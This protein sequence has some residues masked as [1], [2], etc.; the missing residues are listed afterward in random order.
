MESNLQSFINNDILSLFLGILNERIA[1]LILA[2]SFTAKIAQETNST[3]Y[4]RRGESVR[5]SLKRYLLL[6]LGEPLHRL[7]RFVGALKTRHDDYQNK[8]NL[9][10]EDSAFGTLNSQ[11][12]HPW[13]KKALAISVIFST[14]LILALSVLIKKAGMR[15]LYPF[16]G[17]LWFITSHSRFELNSTIRK[18]KRLRRRLG[19]DGFTEKISST[20]II[21]WKLRRAIG[22]RQ[23]P[24]ILNVC[25]CNIHSVV[26]VRQQNFAPCKRIRPDSGHDPGLWKLESRSMNPES[27]AWNPESKTV[28]DSLTWDGKLFYKSGVGGSPDHRLL[29]VAEYECLWPH[30]S[31]ADESRWF[32]RP[33][34]MISILCVSE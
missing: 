31:C 11:T 25:R 33:I 7:L 13:G 26:L 29:P 1:V 10:H 5:T 27:T 3:W 32:S 14:R 8:N 22:T 34:I 30:I 4:K 16:H 20:P 9:D 15:Q 19:F 24:F 17:P 2:D 18:T 28:L 23:D 21:S 12:R 6:Y